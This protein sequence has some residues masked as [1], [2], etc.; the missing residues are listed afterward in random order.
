MLGLSH[1]ALAPVLAPQALYVMARAL[2]LPEAAGP[3]AGQTG[4]G[5]DLRLLILGDSSAAGVGVADQRDALSGQL[6]AR[7]AGHHRV[8]WR[9]IA[10]TGATTATMLERL[11]NAPP[12]RFD[13]AVVALGVNDATRLRPL[14]RWLAE[15]ARL[16]ALL[17]Q[18]FGVARILVS[19]LP[20]LG[21]FPLLPQPLRG[22]LGRHAARMDTAMQ[23]ALARRAEW[24][25]IPFD[26][27]LRPE[28]MASDGFHPGPRIYAMWAERVAAA[29]LAPP[30]TN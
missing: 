14:P 3:R 18:R 10:Q 11:G 5:P 9:L 12:E 25:H 30:T 26:A 27:D 6:V 16:R 2:R 21:A 17:K 7:L 24:R 23:A 1:L 4:Q 13:L 29:I 28:M 22:V 15:Q 20:P 8:D 19:A